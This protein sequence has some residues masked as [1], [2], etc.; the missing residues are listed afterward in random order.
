MVMVIGLVCN[1]LDTRRWIFCWD[2]IKVVQSI[3]YTEDK[4]A[5]DKIV[6]S[7]SACQGSL[8]TK[9]LFISLALPNK[10]YRITGGNQYKG[11]DAATA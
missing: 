6:S 10:K 2:Y 4:G 9:I 11:R 7:Q 3:I 1:L 8:Y 5:G